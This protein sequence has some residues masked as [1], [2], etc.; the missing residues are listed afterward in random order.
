VDKLK[1]ANPNVSPK[2]VARSWLKG[3]LKD[4]EGWNSGDRWIEC[5]PLLVRVLDAWSK[6]TTPIMAVGLG[7]A[8]LFACIKPWAD[9]DPE[10][11]PAALLMRLIL[12]VYT[13]LGV[14]LC[15]WPLRGCEEG[16]DHLWKQRAREFLEAGIT[17]PD[18]GDG[19]GSREGHEE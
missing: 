10:A 2:E 6:N 3:I 18:V 8:G 5:R 12:G 19:T 17:E 9:A 13:A 4:P 11:A 1:R 7:S 14:T 15:A 16:C